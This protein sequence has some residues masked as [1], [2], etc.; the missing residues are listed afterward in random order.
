MLVLRDLARTGLE[1]QLKSLKW[2][3]NSTIFFSKTNLSDLRLD[4][5]G[6]NAK[7]ALFMVIC[8]HIE[9]SVSKASNCRTQDWL[10]LVVGLPGFLQQK[11]ISLRVYLFL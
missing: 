3:K 2:S 4:A 8:I 5:G 1:I 11:G 6:Y 10:S 7:V 9:L